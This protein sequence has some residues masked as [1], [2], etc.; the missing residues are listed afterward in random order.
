MEVESEH[1]RARRGRTRPEAAAAPNAA[2]PP[3][4]NVKPD[5]Q[6]QRL[7]EQQEKRRTNL[8]KPKAKIAKQEQAEAQMLETTRYVNRSKADDVTAGSHGILALRTWLGFDQSVDLAFNMIA[9]FKN[10][11]AAR[12]RNAKC[13]ADRTRTE[14]ASCGASLWRCSQIVDSRR[15]PECFD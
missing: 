3:R 4:G 15:G 10:S 6:A 8:E 9:V 5:G 14:I 12:H 1:P 7:Q 11:K 2:G 13:M